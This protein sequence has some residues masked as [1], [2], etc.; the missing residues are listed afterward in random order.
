VQDKDDE[1]EFSSKAQIMTLMTT[2]VDRVSDFSWHMFSLVGAS[3]SCYALTVCDPYDIK[4]SPIEIAI[5]TY[6]LYTLL[7]MR[8]CS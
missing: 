5:G 2:D 3:P 7:G 1:A 8:R 6:F 4:D